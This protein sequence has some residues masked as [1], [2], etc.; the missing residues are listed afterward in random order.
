[1]AMS[2]DERRVSYHVTFDSETKSKNDYFLLPV[3]L[4]EGTAALRIRYE[5]N[6][7]KI[8]D[9]NVIDLGL[10]G[11][12]DAEFLKV[13]SFRGWSGSNKKEV[14]ISSDAATPGYYAGALEGG[15]WNIMLGLYKISKEGCPCTIEVTVEKGSKGIPLRT[16]SPGRIFKQDAGRGLQWLRGDLHVHSHHSD[17]SLSIAGLA[18]E[19]RRRGLDF[20]A[21]TDHN[22]TSQCQEIS[23]ELGSA[24]TPEPII[25]PGEELTS[26]HGHANIWNTTEWLDF[27]I[28]SENDARAAMEEA[29]RRK[30]LFSINHPNDLFPWEYKGAMEF[31]CIEVWSGLWFR[32]NFQSVNW[33][34]ELARKGIRKVAVGGSDFHSLEEGEARDFFNVGTPTTWILSEGKSPDSII[35]G[36]R[37][38]RTFMSRDPKGPILLLRARTG[39]AE[40]QVGDDITIKSGDRIAF[41]AEVRGGRGQ[42]LRLV[43]N[44]GCI[45]AA[46]VDASD[47]SHTFKQE[48]GDS[49][50]I[51]GELVEREGDWKS[52]SAQDLEM[53]ALTDNFHVRLLP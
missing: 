46:D 7:G 35:D 44:G 18:Q 40:H 20:I 24:A 47:F 42:G 11:P 25:I 16:T 19:A 41:Q 37:G 48:V 22:T 14:R 10:L 43:T 51:R 9:P 1:M 3:V 6:Q 32:M 39:E 28:R 2:S 5:Y 12:G 23:T 49:Q 26:Y 13:S 15:K 30:L 45:S 34:D 38:G 17:G 53:V 29:H 33:W 8:G 27:R 4:P 21:V 31:D 36:I 52:A 50:F